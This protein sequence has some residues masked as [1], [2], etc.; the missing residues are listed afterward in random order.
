MQLPGYNIPKTVFR[1]IFS[2]F[3]HSIAVHMLEAGIPLPVIKNFPGHSSIEVTMIYAS[4]SDE[5]KNKY[6]KEN[7]IAAELAIGCK[8]PTIRAPFGLAP[9]RLRP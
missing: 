5:L 7:G 2:T 4:V 1:L 3:R 6:L 9:I 8:F